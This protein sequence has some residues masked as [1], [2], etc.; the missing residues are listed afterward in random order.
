MK[1]NLKK[2]RWPLIVV[3]LVLLSGYAGFYITTAMAF[4]QNPST[5]AFFTKIAD[6]P[7]IETKGPQ[8]GHFWENGGDCDDRSRVFYNYLKSKG[9][10]GVQICWMARLDENGK[11]ISSYD[12]GMGHEFILWNGRAFNPSINES[13]RFYDADLNEYLAFMK[14][15][16]GFNTLYYENNTEEIPF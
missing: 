9:A 14:N 2:F 16:V 4:P 12:G 13:R 5:Y 3:F 8:I 6:M 11:M 15:L 10:S 1:D 7:Y